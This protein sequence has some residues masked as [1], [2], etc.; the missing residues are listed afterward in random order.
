MFDPKI[1][2]AFIDKNGIFCYQEGK[3]NDWKSS[4]DAH[5]YVTKIYQTGSTKT[6]KPNSL[7]D[8]AILS[9]KMVKTA[10][11]R[12]TCYLKINHG[13]QRFYTHR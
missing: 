12:G 6:A 5:D 1:V 7:G 4:A 2:E 8:L 13:R 9:L 10:R 3:Q 11:N